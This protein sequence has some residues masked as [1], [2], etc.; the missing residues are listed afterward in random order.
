MIL[1]KTKS[2]LHPNRSRQ[3]VSSSEKWNN[4]GMYT[5]TSTL[6][7]TPI[8]TELPSASFVFVEMNANTEIILPPSLETNV[9]TKCNQTSQYQHYKGNPK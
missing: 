9:C 1:H 5:T 3:P 7:F 8:E 2:N 4:A 6:Y